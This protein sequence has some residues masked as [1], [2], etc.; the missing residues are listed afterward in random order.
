MRALVLEEIGKPLVVRNMPDPT[1]TADGVIVRVEANG[2]CRSDWHSWLGHW[3][4][5]GVETPLPHIMGHEFCGVIEDVGKDVTRFKK[6]D[7]VIVPFTQ[8]DGTCPMCQAGHHNVCDNITLPGINI[9]GGYGKFVHIPN[10]DTNLVILPES[11][12]FVEAAGVGCRFMTAFHGVT[13]QAQV[14]PG[15]WVA[16]HGCGGVGLSAIQIITALGA[17]AIAVDIN[18]E[19]LAFAKELGAVATVNSKKENAAESI[20]ELTKGGAHVSVDALGITET[21]Q[22]AINS[23][24]KRGRHL[25]I[26]LTTSNEKG[27]I[28]VPIDLIVINE[29]QIVGS[30]GMQAPRYP[31]M[32]RM[33]ENGILSPKDLVTQT[34]SIEEAGS[35]IESMGNYTNMGVTVVNKW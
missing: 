23:L 15:E 18:D 32:L 19:K 33:I 30:Y 8:G 31:Q 27:M 11:I 7:R 5:L 2:V 14:R 28:P 34:I 20:K 10:A 21:C 22:S 29:I 3:N 24:A 26:G 6:G 9:W 35:V 4:W 1:N 12:D 13:D 16:V 25:Q 17:H